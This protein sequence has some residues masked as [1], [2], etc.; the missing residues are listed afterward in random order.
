MDQST[1]TV[2]MIRPIIFSRNEQTAVNNYFQQIDTLGFGDSSIA[3]LRE[4]DGLA[5][6]MK[7]NGI[8]VVVWQDNPEPQTP[9]ALFPNNWVSFHEDNSVFLY[10]MFAPNRRLERLSNLPERMEKEGFQI[11]QIVDISDLENSGKFLEGTG[12]LVL[13][14]VNK[15]AYACLSERTHSDAL[16]IWCAKSG[17]EVVRFHAFHDANGARMPVYHTNVIMSICSELAIICLESIDD[18]DERKMVKSS[19]EQF[20]QVVEISQEQVNAFAGN[21]LEVKN[22][23]G[24]KFLVMSERAFKNLHPAQLSIIKQKLQILHSPLETI[25]NLGGGSAR[26]MIAE[27][28]LT[29]K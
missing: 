5:N 27:V 3:A 13:D 21:M 25:E 1:N 10:P 16:D 23:N 11:N 18:H 15:L 12:S 29:S 9:D 26:C 2:V 22:S 20:R 17:Y 7:L 19:L 8:N 14:R 4:F 28:F 6:K 24:E